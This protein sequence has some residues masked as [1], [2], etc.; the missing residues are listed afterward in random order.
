M[1]FLRSAY[2]LLFFLVS[3]IFIVKPIAILY[4]WIEKDEEK[5]RLACHRILWRYARFVTLQHGIPGVKFSVGNPNKED[6]EKPAIII[7]NHQSH[8][9]LMTMLIH[10]PKLVCLTKDWVWNNPL[11]GNIIRGAEFYPVSESLEVLLPKL[12]SLIHRGYSIVVY[13]EGTRSLDC[14]IGRFHQGAFHLAKQLDV[15][16]LP[17]ISYGA[18]KA[19]PKKGKLLRKWP[20]RM[21]ID[22]RIRPEEILAFGQTAKAQASKMRRYYEE[23]YTEIANRMEQDV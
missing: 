23:R 20:I 1:T 17:I 3:T 12:R 11:Y 4:Q 22:K 19:L 18:G 14:S 16:V 6:F 8:L 7:C 9:D 5:R 10:T 13:P 15:D 21:E 2:S